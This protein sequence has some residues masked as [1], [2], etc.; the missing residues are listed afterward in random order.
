[1]MIIGGI[2]LK[3]RAAREQRFGWTASASGHGGGI[4]VHGRF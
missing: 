2:A 4:L 3:R 1:V